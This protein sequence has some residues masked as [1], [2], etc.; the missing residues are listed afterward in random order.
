MPTPS[1]Q[2]NVAD[3]DKPK[4]KLRLKRKA[5][6]NHEK[7]ITGCANSDDDFQSARKCKSPKPNDLVESKNLKG[8]NQKVRKENAT[9]PEPY[10]VLHA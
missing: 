5:K 7:S 2:F 1:N 10:P 3:N 6:P 9:S 4:G 8:Q